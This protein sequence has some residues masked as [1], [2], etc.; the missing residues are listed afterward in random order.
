[1][2]SLFNIAAGGQAGFYG[3]QINDSLRFEDGSSSYLNRTPASNGDRQTWTWS[4]WVKRG[5]ISTTQD[6]FSSGI[7]TNPYNYFRFSFISGNSLQVIGYDNSVAY[8]L[9]LKTSQVFRDVSAWYHIVLALDTT[10]STSSDR[11]KLY[12]NGTQITSFITGDTSTTY[13]SLNA[14][15]WVN[16]NSYPANIGRFIIANNYFDG[17]LAD[18]NL[19]DGQALDPTSFGE[20]KSGV[21]IPKDTSGLTFGTN[22][23]RLEFGDSSAI[24]DDTS[25]NGNDYTAN[26]L[27]AHDVVPDS[28]T[29]NYSTFNPLV[30]VAGGSFSEG[31]LKVTTG[32]SQYGA[33]VSSFAVSSGKWYCEFLTT[34]SSG[35]QRIGGVRVG[36]NLTTTYDL[37]NSGSFAYR[38]NDGQKKVDGTQS[39]YGA[40][41]AVNDII[42]MALN[43]DDDEVTFYKN[44]SSQGTFSITT[45][46]YFLA[47]SDGDSGAGM[48]AF[49]NFGQDSTFAGATTAG[50]NSDAN[51]YGDFKYAV[52]SGY[53][54]LNSANLPEPD[55]TPL[56]DDVPEDYFNT[57]LYDGNNDTG[58]QAI[59]G[60]GFQPDFLWLKCRN[61]ANNHFLVDS[62]RGEGT[63]MMGAL[64]SNLTT[65]E[66]TTTSSTNSTFG[67]ISSL[68]SDGFTVDAGAT[69]SGGTNFTGRNY[70]A[71]NWLAGGTAVSNTDGSIT[72]SVSANT[73]AGFSIA[74]YTEPSGS[75]SFGH[76][77]GV[78]PDMFIFKRRDGA[79]N[80]IVWHK[81]FGS[82]T[83]NGLYLDSTL[84]KFTAGA[85]WLTAID[86]DTIT[87]TSGQVSGAGTKV[88][89]AFKSIEGYSKIDTYTGN[90]TI[91]NA[92]VYTGFRP[93]FILARRVNATVNW[94]IHDNKRDIDNYTIHR[95]NPDV[96]VAENSSEL[97]S[98]YGIDFLSNG[99]KIRASHTSTG[100]S[101]T[102]IYMAFAEMPF[103]YANAR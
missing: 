3:Y 47:T 16:S 9:Y 89:Y 42:G 32:S 59:T 93:A 11:A 40:T 35:D 28:P 76:G 97:E 91:N 6:F 100:A 70:V 33:V 79:E 21:W 99:F 17:Y 18:V 22:G 1:M 61:V 80:W 82:P 27:S 86:S 75:F 52:P 63:N 84:G 73:E 15:L 94:F 87:I 66:E 88:C 37:G 85:N 5:N 29:L 13:P 60:V 51:G 83:T 67:I 20:T 14:N 26:N 38:Q 46:E 4:G 65:A 103:K 7:G 92:F 81:H 77:L 50:G 19:I 54:A 48:G 39:A 43:L 36:T 102:Y 68:D 49:T 62:V 24:G 55:I 95:I 44:G 57:V 101:D 8:Q 45:G 53:L 41:W 74:T 90:G 64:F 10:E 12:V 30:N 23:F 25:G 72:S 96:N 58:S 2:S 34:A 31:N 71:W 56:D 78:T 98:T 69:N